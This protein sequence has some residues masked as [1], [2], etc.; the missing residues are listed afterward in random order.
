MNVKTLRRRVAL[1][2]LPGTGE[3]E[4]KARFRLA[5][6]GMMGL[7]RSDVRLEGKQQLVSLQ[8]LLGID[9]AQV[10]EPYNVDPDEFEYVPVPNAPDIDWQA[11][12]DRH[13]E[14]WAPLYDDEEEVEP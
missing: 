9:P 12:L 1:W 5:E 2:L 8:R 6:R 11:H 4:L 13:E 7:P 3:Q 14:T 10:P